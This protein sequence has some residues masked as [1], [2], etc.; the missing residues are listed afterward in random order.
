MQSY[1]EAAGIGKAIALGFAKAGAKVVLTSRK[2][3][4][5]EANVTEIK[6][7][8]GEA[9]RASITLGQNGRDH[10]DGQCRNGKIRQD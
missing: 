4:D 5:L 1:R 10:K 2:L 7:F 3:A 6:T 9:C 8:G